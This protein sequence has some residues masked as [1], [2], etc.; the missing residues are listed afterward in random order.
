MNT[1]MTQRMLVVVGLGFTVQLSA[2]EAMQ[3]TPH[4]IFNQIPQQVIIKPS[5]SPLLNEEQAKPNTS[6]LLN[7][8]EAQAVLNATLV[9]KQNSLKN[10]LAWTV[11]TA[12]VCFGC[13]LLC[14][15][16]SNQ[17]TIVHQ[18]DRIVRK[19]EESIKV[20]GELMN[21]IITNQNMMQAT[22]HLQ[23]SK[24]NAFTPLPKLYN[25]LLSTLSNQSTL[26]ANQEKLLTLQQGLLQ[27]LT[28]HPKS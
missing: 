22:Q 7:Q 8:N 15:L 2:M 27:A 19:Q 6:A 28:Q 1:V 10:M 18:Q 12:A 26:G 25:A 24:L 5:A 16:Y 17:R 9:A 14:G 13:A 4:V 20:H 11:K 23:M 21:T 3:P